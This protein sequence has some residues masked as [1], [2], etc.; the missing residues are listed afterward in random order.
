[1]QCCKNI[2]LSV[3]SDYNHHAR[4]VIPHRSLPFFPWR[5]SQHQC[6][7][8]SEKKESISRSR[9]RERT[10]ITF[11]F[12]L[13]L[14]FSFAFSLLPRALASASCNRSSQASNLFIRL[15]NTNQAMV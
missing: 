7:N 13:A 12:S 1:M 3:L 6:W 10:C 4:N 8:S 14:A 5:D 2:K 9:V 15:M 11:L